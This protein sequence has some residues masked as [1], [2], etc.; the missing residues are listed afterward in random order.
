MAD[1]RGLLGDPEVLCVKRDA[2]CVE[3]GV[4][5]HGG[6]DGEDHGDY[7]PFLPPGVGVA[8]FVVAFPFF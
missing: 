7:A 2:A 6:L 4:P 3:T 8:E 5:V 1:S